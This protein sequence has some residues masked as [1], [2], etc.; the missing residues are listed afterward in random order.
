[1]VFSPFQS[2][3]A[4]GN[5]IRW[6]FF[7]YAVYALAQER[8]FLSAGGKWTVS[9]EFSFAVDEGAEIYEFILHCSYIFAGNV[10]AYHY[11]YFSNIF[12]ISAAVIPSVQAVFVISNGDSDTG[13]PSN[14]ISSYTWSNL[15]S[16]VS[17]DCILHENLQ[18][19]L[20]FRGIWQQHWAVN[21]SHISLYLF[22]PK[23]ECSY[24]YE[25]FCLLFGRINSVHEVIETFV[26]SV[27]SNVF[28]NDLECHISLSSDAICIMPR[29]ISFPLISVRYTPA[30]VDAG[31]MY[32]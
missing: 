17:A 21:F 16:Q 23:S 26:I 22:F 14:S 12:V 19:W 30:A 11:N 9:E 2:L 7:L 24:P 27:F 5:R 13:N 8:I 31:R 6:L 10:V 4:K 29:N 3:R 28:I 32:L 20:Q 15:P 25:Q 18:I 1:M